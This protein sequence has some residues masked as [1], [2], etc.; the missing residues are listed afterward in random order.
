M[1]S[2]KSEN[3]ETGKSIHSPESVELD[4]LFRLSFVTDLRDETGDGC[5]WNVFLFLQLVQ[6][7]EWNVEITLFLRDNGLSRARLSCI[8][9]DML[10]FLPICGGDRL[11]A[12]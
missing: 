3:E 11:A 2:F 12:T 8:G 1:Q 6:S 4:L 5:V 9:G 7:S 10:R